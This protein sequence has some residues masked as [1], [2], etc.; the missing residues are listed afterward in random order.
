MSMVDR[1]PILITGASGFIGG[2]IAT[3][4][5]PRYE[6]RSLSS[7][8]ARNRFGE[9][10][11]TFPYQFANP[12]GMAAAFAGVEVFVNTYYI[13]FPYRGRTFEGAVEHTRVL[14]ACAKRAGVRRIVHVSV[15][16]A[17]EAFDLP[18]YRNK[19]RIERLVRESGLE[20]V[21]L[22]PALVFG[23]GDILIN[24]IAYFL[25][26]FPVFGV[27]GR[28]NYRV[29]PIELEAFAGLAVDAVES[30]EP[31]MVVR[32]AG[33]ADYTY[34]EMVNL[35]KDAVASRA[36]IVPMP[37]WAALTF[38][39]AAGVFLRDVVLTADEMKGLV[40]EYLYTEGPTRAGRSLASWLQKPA[41][42]RTLGTSYAS[43]LARHFR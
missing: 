12:D 11:R 6:V 21:I 8:P 5:L 23:E 22:R 25:R 32:A 41:V 4:L 1:G 24:N 13:R 16:N 34:L 36:A 40:R 26:R 35:I 19:G 31:G 17:D 27:F 42:C 7:H 28:G 18:Y 29:Q 43:E 15:S 14:I 33:P 37:A 2:A 20:H 10:V 9:R 30:I 38:T 3:Q 39:R